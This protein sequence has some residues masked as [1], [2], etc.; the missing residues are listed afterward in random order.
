MSIKKTLTL[1]LLTALVCSFK[2]NLYLDQKPTQQLKITDMV[3]FTKQD[4]LRDL[5][6]A[7]QTSPYK[8]FPDL[9]EGYFYTAGNRITLFAD[10]KRW[11]IVFEK[12]GYANKGLASQIE[13][14]Y[15]GNCLQN[16]K[17]AGLDGRY[18][19]NATYY[20]LISHESFRKIADGFELI[21]PD[22]KTV[23]VR[24]T[25]VPI[26]HDYKKYIKKGINISD[27][28]NPN[29]LIDFVALTRYLDETSGDLFR[30]TDI[31]LHTYLP[32]DIPKIIEIDQWHYKPYGPAYEDQG[33][34]VK[35]SSY[36]T[37]QMI[38]EVLVSGDKSKWK[39]TLSPNNNW[40]NYP[41]AGEL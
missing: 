25:L 18:N 36:E 38:A 39:P 15:F 14:T 21:K 10:K 5:D 27:Y 35:P 6:N 20:N 41:E 32:N 28:K 23:L 9:E 3:A 22:A 37:F 17:K 12:S 2:A 29:K 16:L 34:S 40:R 7:W 19:C 30:A 31:E 24:D 4:I 13:L 26:E 1:L 33:L 8:F 11:A